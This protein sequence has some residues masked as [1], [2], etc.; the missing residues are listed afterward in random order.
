LKVK[1]IIYL[2]KFSEDIQ[3]TYHSRGLDFPIHL[4]GGNE[5]ALLDIYKNYKEGD[6]NL[7]LIKEITTEE[8]ITEEEDKKIYK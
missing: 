2:S 3:N 8:L 7:V 6:T 5:Y 4:S 1:Q